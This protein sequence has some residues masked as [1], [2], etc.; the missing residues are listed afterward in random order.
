MT[1]KIKS[2][3]LDKRLPHFLPY[4]LIHKFLTKI[5][6]VEPNEILLSLTFDIEHHS[7]V[8]KNYLKKFFQKFKN[9]LKKTRS[10]L[11][12]CGKIIEEVAKELRKIQKD[13]ELGLHGYKHELWGDEKWWLNKKPINKKTKIKLIRLSFENFK[14][15]RLKKPISFRAPYMVSNEETLDILN[16]FGFKV[17]SSNCTYLNEDVLP[18]KYKKIV[19][20]PVS[21]NPIP[22]FKKK[23]LI[24]FSFYKI[25]NMEN[26]HVFEKNEILEFV[27]IVTS[28]QQANG[29]RPYL[30]FLAHPWEFIHV[31]NLAYCSPKNYSVLEKIV[32]ILEENY[33]IKF[34]KIAELSKEVFK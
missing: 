11:F 29:I 27:K 31:K 19:R 30:V 28:F 1:N 20:I 18:S 7:F 9:L 13:C 12:V 21:V 34:L 25:F 14:K 2:F 5:E 23:F 10:T 17:D 22:I 16:N 4:T 3:L 24:P 8:E 6:I 33:K 15:N 32:N 26:F